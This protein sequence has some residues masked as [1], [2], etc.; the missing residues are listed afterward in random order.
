MLTE[1]QQIKDDL[2]VPRRVSLSALSLENNRKLT[3]CIT[4]QHTQKEREKTAQNRTEK[5]R[6]QKK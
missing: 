4:Y 2:R 6:I 5:G 1:E 3:L